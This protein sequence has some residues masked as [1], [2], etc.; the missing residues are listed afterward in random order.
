MPPFV[1]GADDLSTTHGCGAPACSPS[2]RRPLMDPSLDTL[3]RAE[4][5]AL[6]PRIA[7]AAGCARCPVPTADC[8]TASGRP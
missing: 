3:L 1:I 5:A 4:L 7:S 8:A 2:A 6:E